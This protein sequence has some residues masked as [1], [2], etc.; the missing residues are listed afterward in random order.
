MNPTLG[1][2]EPSYAG[3]ARRAECTYAHTVYSAACGL[4]HHLMAFFDAL[5]IAMINFKKQTPSKCGLALLLFL[6]PSCGSQD[7]EPILSC[8]QNSYQLDQLYDVLLI[9]SSI[10]LFAA[11]CTIWI[12]IKMV[13]SEFHELKKS[14]NY[15]HHNTTHKL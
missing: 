13:K 15:T 5:G 2:V 7:P 4:F 1:F 14:K 10:G 9:L 11:L 8:W 6:L 3:L 12:L